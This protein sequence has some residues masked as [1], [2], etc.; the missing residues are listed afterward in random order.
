MFY[1]YYFYFLTNYYRVGNS[2]CATDV[3]PRRWIKI[4]VLQL[5][6]SGAGSAER[7]NLTKWQLFLVFHPPR[8]QI[9]FISSVGGEG[10]PLPLTRAGGVGLE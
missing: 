4:N 2:S 3:G 5:L 10:N 7:S 1:Y 9:D 8:L 6:F